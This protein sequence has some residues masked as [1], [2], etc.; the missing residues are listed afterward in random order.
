MDPPAAPCSGGRLRRTP[1][2]RVAKGAPLPQNGRSRQGPATQRAFDLNNYDKIIG[3][4]AVGVVLAG[5]LMLQLSGN[6]LPGGRTPVPT[7]E[8]VSASAP[9]RTMPLMD[10]GVLEASLRSLQNQG[11]DL[12]LPMRLRHTVRADDGTAALRLTEWARAQGYEVDAAVPLVDASR[13]GAVLVPIVRR[14]VP[15]PERIRADG[16]QIAGYASSQ[17][18]LEYQAWQGE[19][20]RR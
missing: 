6:A 8:P 17:P 18:G 13:A 5:A 12:R 11:A 9:L 3:G 15:D 14:G 16:L 20:V 10:K 4:A 7:P 19:I 1:R 2:A